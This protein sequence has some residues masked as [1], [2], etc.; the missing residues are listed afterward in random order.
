MNG[1][2]VY[3]CIHACSRHKEHHIAREHIHEM[4]GKIEITIMF[5]ETL[6]LEE[7][8]I[9]CSA[10]EREFPIEIMFKHA[11]YMLYEKYEGINF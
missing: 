4:G 11:A 9:H 10:N 5:N 7:N 2:C 1:I 8:I 6:L 3:A